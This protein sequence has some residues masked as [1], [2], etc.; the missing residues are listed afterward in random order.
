LNSTLDYSGIKN[1]SITRNFIASTSIASASIT[2]DSI[3]ANV[4]ITTS[5]LTVNGDAN[6]TGNYILNETVIIQN[7]RNLVNINS[8]DFHAPSLIY[9]KLSDLQRFLC[10]MVLKYMIRNSQ[11]IAF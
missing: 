4:G 8:I 7:T 3:I 6:V 2:C 11:Q 5:S 1:L 9:K 10:V